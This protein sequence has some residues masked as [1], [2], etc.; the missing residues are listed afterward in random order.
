VGKIVSEKKDGTIIT[1]AEKWAKSIQKLNRNSRHHFNQ[2]H[3]KKKNRKVN[4]KRKAKLHLKMNRNTKENMSE[5][6]FGHENSD[7]CKER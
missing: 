6:D 3:D 5:C 4:M 7:V 1:K 2:G